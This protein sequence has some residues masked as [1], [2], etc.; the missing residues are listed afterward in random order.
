MKLIADVHIP[1][2]FEA[3]RYH[4]DGAKIVPWSNNAVTWHNCQNK[5]VESA[6]FRGCWDEMYSGP[7][8]VYWRGDHLYCPVCGEQIGTNRVHTITPMQADG[9]IPVDNITLR[10][11]TGRERLDIEMSYTPVQV[12]PEA[13]GVGIYLQP[14]R[15]VRDRI[16]FDFRARRTWYI[17]QYGTTN[18]KTAELLPGPYMRNVERGDLAWCHTVFDLL[19][20]SSGAKDKKAAIVEFLRKVRTCHAA[21]LEKK[22]GHKVLNLYV[23][24]S[25][26]KGYLAGLQNLIWALRVSDGPAYSTLG[27]KTGADVYKPVMQALYENGPKAPYIRTLARALG[28]P[29][30]K[31]IMALVAKLPVRHWLTTQYLCQV[32]HNTDRLRNSISRLHI[33]EDGIGSARW[34]A[35][36]YTDGCARLRDWIGEERLLRLLAEYDTW[37]V[38]DTALTIQLLAKPVYEELM[39]RRIPLARLHDAVAEAYNQQKHKNIKLT[40]NRE[41][42]AWQQVVDGVTYRLPTDTA[43]LYRLGRNLHNCVNTYRERVLDKRVTIVWAQQDKETVMC[44]EIRDGA[45]VQ[46]K[47]DCNVPV[48]KN[49][50][51]NRNILQYAQISRLRIDTTDIT[52]GGE[53][54][55]S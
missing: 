49:E 13:L 15:R 19:H 11:Y 26:K 2:L 8:S 28:A 34:Q 55:A 3:V 39:L 6:W 46:A 24:A 22:V 20:N 36:V 29:E 31:S 33:D 10:A 53:A 51:L 18:A 48:R 37:E 12:V 1:R 23:P 30:K 44:L 25:G 45:I 32:F 35:L 40:Y 4:T 47:L 52:V 14:A 38:R 42:A 27:E 54:V 7:G 9:P 21:M 50:T 16:R 41:E 17:Q 43:T 5:R